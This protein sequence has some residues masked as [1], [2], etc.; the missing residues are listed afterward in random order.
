MSMGSEVLR[1]VR[2]MPFSRF[3]T[4]VSGVFLNPAGVERGRSSVLVS[5]SV[6]SSSYLEWYPQI[7]AKLIAASEVN[8][9]EMALAEGRMELL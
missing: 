5:Y 1:S 6:V 3:F 8:M 7:R 2:R 4:P 9:R